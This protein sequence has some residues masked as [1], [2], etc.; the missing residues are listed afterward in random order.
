MVIGA[1]VECV[2]LVTRC[3]PQYTG[4]HVNPVDVADN[5]TPFRKPTHRTQPKQAKK[6]T[7]LPLRVGVIR[8]VKGGHTPRK[9]KPNSNSPE[10]GDNTQVKYSTR[11]T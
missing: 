5:P 10:K 7:P 9:H 11:K 2:C 6:V 4:T 3:G 1:E 8:N